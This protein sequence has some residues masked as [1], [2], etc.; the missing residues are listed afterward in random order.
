MLKKYVLYKRIIK[1]REKKR[2]RENKWPTEPNNYIKT[3]EYTMIQS[4]GRDHQTE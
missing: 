4:K 1:D 2:H 3:G